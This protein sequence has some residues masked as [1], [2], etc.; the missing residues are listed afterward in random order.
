[1]DTQSERLV[2]RAL[3]AAS[4]GRTTIV[5]AH[6]LSTIR[7]ADL[8]V[9]MDQGELV[10]LGTHDTLVNYNG[11][12][13]ELV[14][15]QK[16]AIKKE[17]QVTPDAGNSEELLCIENA[18]LRDRSA[19]EYQQH[20]QLR[21][22]NPAIIQ[23]PPDEFHVGAGG[24]VNL[25]RRST[26]RSSIMDAYELKQ[27]KNKQELKLRRQQD[28]P[29]GKM[30]KQVQ[31]EWFLI[32]AGCIGALIAGA[33]YPLFA[34]TAGKCIYV[35]ILPLDQIAP[36]PFEGVNLYA[37]LFVVFGAIAFVGYGLQNWMFELVDA[38]YTARL[39]AMLLR[40]YLKQEIGFFDHEDNTAGALTSKLAADTKAMNEMISKVPG[41]IMQAI[42]TTICGMSCT[43]MFFIT[44]YMIIL[45]LRVVNCKTS[46][47]KILIIK[48][49][50]L[51]NLNRFGGC[52]CARMGTFTYCYW[53][54]S[55]PYRV[56]LL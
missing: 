52:F 41:D 3:D 33:V 46:L 29:I 13:A 21:K 44:V 35:L 38:R 55:F 34:F 42:S 6:R 32:F 12:Y 10:E 39:R 56:Q 30:W 15:K 50:F 19:Q 17:G 22:E 53:H 31:S 47:Y 4:S 48:F 27:R 43:K 9:V 1:M 8:I 26:T 7:N 23:V 11:V 14:R 18:R 37:F 36:G 49:L 2:Q 28:A 25:V 16:I 40:A 24:D 5:V 54:V 20:S 45:F 51:L